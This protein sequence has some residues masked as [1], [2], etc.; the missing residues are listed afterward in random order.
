MSIKAINWAFSLPLPPKQKLVLL[1][2]A[3]YADDAGVCWPS[4]RMLSKKSGLSLRMVCYAMAG[5][6]AIDIV[7]GGGGRGATSEMALSLDVKTL[8]DDQISEFKR[9]AFHR[10]NDDQIDGF[11]DGKICTSE[12]KLCTDEQK[13]CAPGCI[14]MCTVVHQD[15]H[16]RAAHIDNHQEPPRTASSSLAHTSEPA[17]AREAPDAAAAA[18][19]V[20]PKKSDPDHA[21][22]VEAAWRPLAVQCEQI[23][24]LDRP[25]RFAGTAV[26][27]VVRQWMVDAVK[28][29]LSPAEAGCLIIE[30]VERVSGRPNFSC[31]SLGYFS[32]PVAKALCEAQ[33]QKKFA[34]LRAPADEF[35]I[36]E[37]ERLAYLAYSRGWRSYDPDAVIEPWRTW[38]QNRRLAHVAA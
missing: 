17:H 36:T 16:Q 24:G 19:E 34:A 32:Q 14:K 27:G 13:R 29:G 37:E 5:F 35:E 18:E 3:D 26:L 31:H 2:L 25:G 38:I 20:D 4:T 10:S 28:M 8:S 1:A 11:N 7:A 15:V 21:A 30:V 12:P 9:V 22:L 6:R 33:E 23:A